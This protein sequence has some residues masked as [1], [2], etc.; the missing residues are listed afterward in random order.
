MGRAP[1]DVLP[2]GDEPAEHLDRTLAT[3]PCSPTAETCRPPRTDFLTPPRQ[4]L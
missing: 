4:Y 3:A 1:A 2:H